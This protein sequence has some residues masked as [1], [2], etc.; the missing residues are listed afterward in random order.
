[1]KRKQ[2]LPVIAGRI[3]FAALLFVLAI[4]FT[5]GPVHGEE[6]GDATAPAPSLP[7]GQVALHDAFQLK[8]YYYAYSHARIDPNEFVRYPG[9][10]AG[11]PKGAVLERA[12]DG[13]VEEARAHAD[14]VLD[15]KPIAL[16]QYDA[17]RRVFPMDNRLFV[18]GME[19]YFDVSPYHYSYEAVPKLNG[20]RCT[21]ADM[22]AKIAK[23]VRGYRQFN[24]RLYGRVKS[25]DSQTKSVV[26]HLTKFQLLDDR[27]RVLITRDIGD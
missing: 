17:A 12:V 13:A 25:A 5:G 20:I 26:I 6:S 18:A 8:A 27:E 7:S 1:M 4:L 9:D 19:Y 24:M 2:H 16:Q 14:V 3:V 21:D 22:I 10:A 23:M 15:L 11:A